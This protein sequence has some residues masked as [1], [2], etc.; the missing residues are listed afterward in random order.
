M[1][2]LHIATVVAEVVLLVGL[3]AFI[4]KMLGEAWNMYWDLHDH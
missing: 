3:V 4:S 1:S 2:A